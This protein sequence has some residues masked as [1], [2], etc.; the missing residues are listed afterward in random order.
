MVG[1]V[2]DK[3]LGG[4]DSSNATA[5]IEAGARGVACIRW[6]LGAPDPAA[7]AIALWKAVSA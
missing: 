4:V 1:N 2:V 3:A 7:A 5:C 6:V